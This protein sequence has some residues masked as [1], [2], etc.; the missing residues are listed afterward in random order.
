[1]CLLPGFEKRKPKHSAREREREENRKRI[2]VRGLRS[3][4]ERRKKKLKIINAPRLKSDEAEP[5][6]WRK[7]NFR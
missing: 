2:T 4:L 7:S 3:A 1:V 5:K 6:S